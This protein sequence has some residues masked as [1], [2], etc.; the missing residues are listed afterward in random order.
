MQ[1]ASNLLF[2]IGCTVFLMSIMAYLALHECGCISMKE[3]S[4]FEGR[5]YTQAPTF[6]ANEFIDGSYQ[7]NTESF[8]SDHL[9]IR[10]SVVMLNAEIQR[11]AIEA[12]NV[13]FSWEC[14]PAYFGCSYSVVASTNTVLREAEKKY[15]P[16]L[17][18]FCSRL[19][20]FANRYPDKRFVVYGAESSYSLVANPSQKYITGSITTAEGKRLME[21]EFGDCENVIVLTN[22]YDSLES[23]YED[24]YLTDFHWNA[25]G[26]AEAYNTIAN[27]LGFLQ[28]DTST[29]VPIAGVEYLGSESRTALIPRSEPV[30]DIDYNYDSLIVYHSDGTIETGSEHKRYAEADSQHIKFDFYGVYFG[31]PYDTYRID[32]RLDN[33]N[34]KALLIT[35]SYGNA[36][37]RN[38]ALAYE[39]LYVKWD[40][41]Y[42]DTADTS[43]EAYLQETE[44]DDIYFI[45]PMADYRFFCEKKASF[46]D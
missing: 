31:T 21:E 4:W 6:S 28:I 9:P 1:K 44:A 10:D 17:K 39:T 7:S 20:Q 11:V 37:M 26:A 38:L 46:F 2:T 13:L 43:L 19:R 24:Y 40:F 16:Q 41:Y 22:P 15:E 30:F 35:N 18:V 23:Y 33:K 36:I 29:V 12:A 3:Y 32:S 27:H 42:K 14:Q 45:G 25:K 8:L 34:R 5:S